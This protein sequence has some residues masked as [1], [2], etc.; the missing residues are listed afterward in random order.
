LKDGGPEQQVKLYAHDSCSLEN[1]IYQRMGGVGK[2]VGMDP[3]TLFLEAVFQDA[4]GRWHQKRL[5]S[6]HR[7][8]FTRIQHSS[9]REIILEFRGTDC[10]YLFLGEPTLQRVNKNLPHPPSKEMLN[11]V[12]ES[13]KPWT[14]SL[15]LRNGEPTI[16]E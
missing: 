5:D 11:Q 16:K 7:T 15:I 12:R 4:S 6:M 2:G 3:N 10:G 9:A 13:Q 8:E 14:M 1:R